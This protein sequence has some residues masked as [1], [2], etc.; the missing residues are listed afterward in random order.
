[1]VFCA[2]AVIG[3][4]QVIAGAAAVGTTK[5]AGTMAIAAVGST[6]A[7]IFSEQKGKK[8]NVEK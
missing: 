5:M 2:T 4:A 8:E 1:M 3:G 7:A 6:W